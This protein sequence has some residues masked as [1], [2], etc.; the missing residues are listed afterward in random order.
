MEI[1]RGLRDGRIYL[2]FCER[3]SGLYLVVYTESPD[4]LEL[5]ARDCRDGHIE[6]GDACAWQICGHIVQLLSITRLV[7]EV[8]EVEAFESIGLQ[9]DEA[10]SDDGALT[11]DGVGAHVAIAVDEFARLVGDDQ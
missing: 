2:P 10:G 1:V 4:L 5:V 6:A 9:F 3:H 11:V 8:C 7:L